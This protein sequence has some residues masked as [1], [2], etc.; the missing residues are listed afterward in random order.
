MTATASLVFAAGMWVMGY[1][2]GRIRGHD[3]A[4]T[5]YLHGLNDL[6]RAQSEHEQ[7]MH[8]EWAAIFPHLRRPKPPKE[9]QA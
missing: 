5:K 7:R 4:H 3:V 9:M 8:K 2:A 1:I 6:W